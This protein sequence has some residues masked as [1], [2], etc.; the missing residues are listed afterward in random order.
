MRH[1]LRPLTERKWEAFQEEM[2]EHDINPHPEEKNPES[3]SVEK[4]TPLDTERSAVSSVSEPEQVL[5][6]A[7]AEKG[8]IIDAGREVRARIYMG[9]VFLGWFWF[10]PVFHMPPPPSS[11]AASA[12]YT[13]SANVSHFALSR[14]QVDF[15]IAAG[16]ALVGVDVSLEWV[17]PGVE[18]RA[19][20]REPPK[21]QTSEGSA[22]GEGG[23]PSSGILAGIQTAISDASGK[24]AVEALGASDQ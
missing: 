1:T 16:A 10:I 3:L 14:K 15:P 5:D 17:I 22:K 18:T 11:T 19:D 9:Q 4:S 21:T 24:E 6:S 8:V 20:G 23:E 12:K 13:P 7:I 2:R